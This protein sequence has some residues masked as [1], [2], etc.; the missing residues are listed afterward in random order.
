MHRSDLL[1]A[2]LN[3]GAV[4]EVQ[5]LWSPCSLWSVVCL[6]LELW[7]TSM[8]CASW[9]WTHVLLSFF[10]SVLSLSYAR[11]LKAEHPSTLPSATSTAS[12]SSSSFPTRTSV[13]TSVTVRE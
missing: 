6:P 10:L 4:G 12:S 13:S 7:L 2:P 9:S 5:K 3:C 1:N 11:M 8:T